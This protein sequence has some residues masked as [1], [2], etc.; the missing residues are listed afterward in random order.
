MFLFGFDGSLRNRDI[1]SINI[2]LIGS[3][4]VHFSAIAIFCLYTVYNEKI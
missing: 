4:I 3:Q 2:Y 1:V